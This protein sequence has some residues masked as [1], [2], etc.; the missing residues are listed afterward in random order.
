MSAQPRSW[1]AAACAGRPVHCNYAAIEVYACATALDD[2]LF[3]LADD[4]AGDARRSGVGR[5]AGDGVN[6]DRGSAIPEDGMLLTTPRYV[7]RH[8][9]GVPPSVRSHTHRAGHNLP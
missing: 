7:R 1:D 4:A 6:H 5:S 9:G 2:A 3:W 8:D